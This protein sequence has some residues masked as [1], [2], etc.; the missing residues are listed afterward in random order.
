[1]TCYTPIILA[2]L[3]AYFAAAAVWCLF[4]Y[5]ADQA[6]FTKLGKWNFYC[7]QWLGFRIARERVNNGHGITVTK[8]YGILITLPTGG[9]D[10]IHY[11][12]FRNPRYYHLFTLKAMR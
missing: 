12:P 6:P 7:C 2:C 4:A 10:G 11:M 5:V 8:G 1:M 3:F 9:W